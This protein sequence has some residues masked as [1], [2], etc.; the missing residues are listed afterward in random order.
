M[1]KNDAFKDFRTVEG[2]SSSAAICAAAATILRVAL[3]ELCSL[4]SLLGDRVMTDEQS[5][6]LLP[7]FRAVLDSL[8]F[9]YKHFSSAATS[10]KLSQDP[11]HA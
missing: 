5:A 10:L 1:K 4:N 2:F 11:D 8:N 9:G 6:R 7:D 3:G